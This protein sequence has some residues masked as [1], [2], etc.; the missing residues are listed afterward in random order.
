MTVFDLICAR[1]DELRERF[2]QAVADGDH[3]MAMTV[4]EE[5]GVLYALA[6]ELEG[7]LLELRYR[8]LERRFGPIASD[9]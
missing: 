3:R 5:S 6:R 8:E 2:D 4:F 1:M 7:V 9:S